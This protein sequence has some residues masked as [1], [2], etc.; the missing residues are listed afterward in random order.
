MCSEAVVCLLE[1]ASRAEKAAEAVQQFVRRGFDVMDGPVEFAICIDLFL[2]QEALKLEGKGI[3]SFSK[4]LQSAK[5]VNHRLSMLNGSFLPKISY[6]ACSGNGL[7][8]LHFAR[9]WKK[10]VQQFSGWLSKNRDENPRMR[11]ILMMKRL[12]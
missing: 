9:S 6:W 1:S 10:T 4:I 8:F 12:D 5:T 11:K 2:N 3:L 7:R